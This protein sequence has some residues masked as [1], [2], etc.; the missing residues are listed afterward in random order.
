MAGSTVPVKPVKKLGSLWDEITEINRQLA[1]RGFELFADRGWL[2]GHDLDDWLQAEREFLW[3]PCAEL[4]E[5][6]EAVRASFALAG[7]TPKD[8]EVLVEPERLTVRAATK[9]EHRKEEGDLRFCE[10]HRGKL[11]RSIALPSPV[12]PEEGKAELKE[13]MLTVTL[14]KEKAGRKI[15]I[16]G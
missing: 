12:L 11:Y 6:D 16:E 5:T 9:H 15:P 10:F 4:T 14:P 8:V 7:L 13:G 2:V 1:K 3:R